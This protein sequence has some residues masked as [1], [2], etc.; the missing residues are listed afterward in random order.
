MSD[1]ADEDEQILAR[2]DRIIERVHEL[3]REIFEREEKITGLVEEAEPSPEIDE[4]VEDGIERRKVRHLER[5]IRDWD[6]LVAESRKLNED[7]LDLVA[8]M[9]R[10]AGDLLIIQPEGIDVGWIRRL[11]SYLEKQRAQVN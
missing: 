11:E 4:L 2:T 3:Q 5:L 7:D 10:F 1:R 9:V 6:A 8:A